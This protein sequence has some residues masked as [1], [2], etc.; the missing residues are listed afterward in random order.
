MNPPPTPIDNG[1]YASTA[2]PTLAT[3]RS[4]PYLRPPLPPSLP[5]STSTRSIRSV[6]SKGSSSTN[7]THPSSHNKVEKKKPTLKPAR[8]QLYCPDCKKDIKNGFDKHFRAH[9]HDLVGSSDAEFDAHESFG[10]GYC[11]AQGVLVEGGQVFHGAAGLVQHV[12][13]QHAS[14]PQ[15]LH[16][17]ISHSFNHVLSAQPHFRRKILAMIN[18]EN[19]NNTIPSLSWIPDHRPLLRK[20]QSMSGRIDRTPS[21]PADD[22]AIDTLLTQVYDAAAQNWQQPFAFAPPTSLP[23]VAS[24]APSRSIPHH[25]RPTQSEYMFT[26]IGKAFPDTP[27]PKHHSIASDM[28]SPS[29]LSPPPH[30]VQALPHIQHTLQD[31]QDVELDDRDDSLSR[32]GPS[33]VDAPLATPMITFPGFAPF[34]TPPLSQQL[35]MRDLYKDLQI[36]ERDLFNS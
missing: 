3:A 36:D 23:H 1:G 18:R 14:T 24:N 17:D 22:N 9:L 11:H 10:C 2:T 27:I 29:I 6:S 30:V 34:S 35:S 13:D 7:V 25:P 15:R 31:P 19:H 21:S 4:T 16:W 20:L 28:R 26:G 32:A 12:K 33:V 5:R 8:K